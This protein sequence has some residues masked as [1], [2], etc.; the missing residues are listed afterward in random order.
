MINQEGYVTS[1]ERERTGFVMGGIGALAVTAGIGA[2]EFAKTSIET[3]WI[4]FSAIVPGSILV[5][6]GVV[7]GAI[8]AKDAF[9]GRYMGRG[10]WRGD[11]PPD[12]PVPPPADLRLIRGGGKSHHPGPFEDP[13]EAA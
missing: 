9:M 5:L 13:P 11:P 1:A 8:G 6:G 2:I 7:F 3:T 12:E 4:E 10:Y